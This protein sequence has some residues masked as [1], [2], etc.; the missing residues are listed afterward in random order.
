MRQ[1][2]ETALAVDESERKAIAK[3]AQRSEAESRLKAMISLAESE[4]G[5]PITQGEFDRDPWLLNCQNGTLDLRTGELREHR[6]GDFI[7]R[8]VPTEY[9][10]GARSELFQAFLDRIL[11][12]PEVQRFTQKAAGYS[13]TG[14]TE[15][16]KL[17][18]P[19]GPAA[20]GKSS[21]I[22][23][24]QACMG[25]YAVMA[26]FDTFLQRSYTTG[27]ARNDIARLAGARLVASIEVEDGKRLAEGLINQLTGGDTVTARFLY[28]ES[29]EFKPAFKLWL[30]AN[31][32]PSISGPEG[33]IWRR[34]VQ[35]PFVQEIPEEERDPTIKAKLQSTE[36]TAVL[37]WL[38][39]GCLLWQKEGL[40]EPEAVKR[41]TGE[42][43][44]ESDP[45]R[46]FIQERC[47]LDPQAQAGN[48][49]IWSVYQEWAK[50]AGERWS[51]GRKKF[52]QA[53]M[54]RGLDQYRVGS[55]RRW[56]GIGV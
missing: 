36:R 28:A 39:E 12:D 48:A 41:M 37:A 35:I 46:D 56:I 55:E 53:L 14:S 40:K 44:E 24:M 13:I 2:C 7:T 49:E 1:L 17:F 45:L 34:L 32:R 15:L 3:H 9:D 8:L 20:T 16:E 25:D 18:F 6:R 4:P 33:A 21:L 31:N 38:V 26:D 50:E 51:L 10:P 52:S 54:A 30:V 19:Y 23:A 11:P 43:K 22:S 27:G 42:Y 5:I 29:F 47:T